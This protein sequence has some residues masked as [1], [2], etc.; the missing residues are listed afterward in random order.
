MQ[1]VKNY[2]YNAAYQAFLLVVP[3]INTPYLARVFGPNGAGINAYT[4]S[5]T[6]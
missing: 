6:Q 5:I 3:L 2:L 4:N 1:V